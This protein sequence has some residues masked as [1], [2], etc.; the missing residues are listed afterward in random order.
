[1]ETVCQFLQNNPL[2]FIQIVLNLQINIGRMDHKIESL[3]Y[4]VSL[5]LF[6]FKFLATASSLQ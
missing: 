1:M 3:K 2:F 4:G 5:N 6:V